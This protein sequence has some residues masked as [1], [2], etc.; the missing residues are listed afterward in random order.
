MLDAGSYGRVF[1]QAKRSRDNLFTVLYRHNDKRVPRLGLAISKKNC[2]LAV[3]RNRLKR[4]VRE[5][6]RQHQ[7]AL[8][9]IDIVVL[10]QS[11][12]HKS[13]NKRLLESLAGH[14]RQCAVAGK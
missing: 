11:G 2:R 8:P 13:N 12:T 9:G 6:F 7:A 3:G 14:W 4:I 1:R 5:S 10:N